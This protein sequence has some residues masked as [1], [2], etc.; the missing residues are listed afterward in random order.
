MGLCVMDKV[1][2]NEV[3]FCLFPGYKHIYIKFGIQMNTYWG[4]CN[5]KLINTLVG[6]QKRPSDE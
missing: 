5:S 1:L 3:L 2:M 4:K 6:H